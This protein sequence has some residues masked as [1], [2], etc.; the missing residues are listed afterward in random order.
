M[1]S[2]FD[3]FGY[4][5]PKKERYQLI[6]QV[7]FDK[8][9]LWWSNDFGDENFQSNPQDAR[10]MGLIIEN[11]HTPF[12]DV[13][14]FWLNNID[15]DALF[16]NFLSI[17]DDCGDNEIPIMVVHLSSGNNPPPFNEM[18]LNRIKKIIEKAE[19]RNVNVAFENLRKTE[20]LKYVLGNI[21]SPRAGFCYDSGHHNCWAA[22][23]DLLNKYGSRLM[24]LHL[25]DNDGSD[26]QHLLPFEGTA[27]WPSIMEGI[28]KTGFTGAVS[29]EAVNIGYE[30]MSAKEFL[31][32]LFSRAKRL[33]SLMKK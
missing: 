9:S 3:F 22:N 30:T 12:K 20:Y 2:T 7:G 24:T 29:M 25:H 13:N 18:G 21:A 15:G 6:K 14:N 26:D 27:D 1:T 33:E 19:K 16:E 10:E 28:A 8:V 31:H 5:I 32:E 23:E 4:G 17:V 11:I